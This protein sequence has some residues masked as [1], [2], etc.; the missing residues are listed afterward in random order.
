MAD[1][2]VLDLIIDEFMHNIH[3]GM[4]EV[5]YV[6]NTHIASVFW[7]GF[8]APYG[9]DVEYD[10]TRYDGNGEPTGATVVLH[11]EEEVAQMLYDHA[12][13]LMEAGETE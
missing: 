11:D 7:Y 9:F 3:P 12:R 8:D 2:S 13:V 10:V 4:E 1:K 5:L 6:L